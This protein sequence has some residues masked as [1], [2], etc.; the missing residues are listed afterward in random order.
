M[1]TYV[2]FGQS[3]VHS[4]NGRTFDKDCVAIVHH[5][6]IEEGRRAVVKYFGLKFC[7][8]YAERHFDLNVMNYFPRGFI[9]VNPEDSTDKKR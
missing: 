4:I 2:T 6:T 8:E 3:H 1:R 7:F 9:H 5:N